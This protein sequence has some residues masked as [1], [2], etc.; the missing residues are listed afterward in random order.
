MIE[1]ESDIKSVTHHSKEFAYNHLFQN[2]TL[3]SI[4]NFLTFLLFLCERMGERTHIVG[5]LYA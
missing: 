5:M 4:V 1:S 3:P 2:Q